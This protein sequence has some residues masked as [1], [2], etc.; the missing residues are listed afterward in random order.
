MK[1]LPKNPKHSK[2]KKEYKCPC[3]KH[4]R[5]SEDVKAYAN[6]GVG[7]QSGERE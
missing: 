4:K 5:K 2:E 1:E 7:I 6:I 3:N